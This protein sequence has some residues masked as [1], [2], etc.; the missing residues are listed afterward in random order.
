MSSEVETHAE[1]A[2]EEEDD[3]FGQDEDGQEPKSTIEVQRNEEDDEE[4]LFGQDEDGAK[5]KENAAESEP[6]S[7]E[8]SESVAVNN[9]EPVDSTSTP[10]ETGTVALDLA[11]VTS[12]VSS[13]VPRKTVVSPPKTLVSVPRKNQGGSH[14]AQKPTQTLPPQV[15]SQAAKFKLPE[16]VVFPDTLDTALLEGRILE[17]LRQLPA[18]L[19]NDAL[20]EYDDAIKQ[21]KH[22]RSHGAYLLES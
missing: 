19:C 15:G 1:Q 2:T 21:Q 4:D 17:T 11:K 12:P 20:Q 16:A 22:I 10:R 7:Q 3:L 9:E 5:K 18:N 6:K 14:L 13:P 8:A